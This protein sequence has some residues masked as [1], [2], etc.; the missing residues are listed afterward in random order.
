MLAWGDGSVA[1]VFALQAWGSESEPQ[2]LSRKTNKTS[3][4]SEGRGTL[5]ILVL[6]RE[7]Q[8]HG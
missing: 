6:R 3:R 5:T 1:E 8:A 2:N 7:R 4:H